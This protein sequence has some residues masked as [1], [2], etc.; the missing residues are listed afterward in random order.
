ME[1]I[2][3]FIVASD[4]H[5]HK[6]KSFNQNNRRLDNLI[7]LVHKL[8]DM[9]NM[10]GATLLIAGDIFNNMQLIQTEVVVATLNAFR[11]NANMYPD[12][13]CIIISGNHDFAQ[14][15]FFDKPAVSGVQALDGLANNISIID[16]GEWD[17]HNTHVF[18]LPYYEYKEDLVK[19]LTELSNKANFTKGKKI[20]LMHQSIGF[21]N[22]LV[23]D[24]ID[25]ED[26]LFAYF[27]MVFNGH[28]HTGSKI[29]D[30]FYNVGSP[31]HRDA[32]DIG[33]VKGVIFYDTDKGV[34]RIE[35]PGYPQYRYLPAGQ[36]CPDEWLGDY[37]LDLPVEIEVA[38]EE[39]EIRE[40]FDHT[41]NSRGNLINNYINI[42]M[43]SE[44]PEFA[45]R[46]ISY[47]AKLLS[48][49]IE[50]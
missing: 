32:N 1:K 5:I 31:I 45:K 20:L 33:K 10:R 18:G 7:R 4:L 49:A 11:E 12:V 21:G 16:N 48:H 37:V 47:G 26:N 15:N 22:D 9:A 35:L 8:W 6:Y 40:G 43:V 34:E 42:K 36:T 44:E 2:M 29:N 13:D 38:P 19:A 3:K 46:I 27:D 17:M 28:I 24:D 39:Q 50:V 25:P 41:R 30:G 14:K 23:P